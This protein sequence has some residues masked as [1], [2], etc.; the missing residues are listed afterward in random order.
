MKWG[1]NFE[2][3]ADE[4]KSLH[5]SVDNFFGKL[6]SAVTTITTQLMENEEKSSQRRHKTSEIEAQ[7][8][9]LK[10]KAELLDAQVRAKNAGIDVDEDLEAAS[11]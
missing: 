11:G 10:A 9:L 3:T 8:E 1:Y 5:K 2:R 4:S 6:S 7:A